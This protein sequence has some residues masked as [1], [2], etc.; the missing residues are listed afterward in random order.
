MSSR[1]A[2]FIAA[3]NALF[4]C[5]EATSNEQYAAMAATDQQ[6]VC[7]DEHAAVANFLKNDDVSFANLIE[8]RIANLNAQKMWAFATT[9]VADN[10]Q[11]LFNLI[12]FSKWS[13]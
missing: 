3:N 13:I 2:Q 7:K 9:N 11:H 4:A 5:M 8:A 10:L 1:Y 6:D 12:Y